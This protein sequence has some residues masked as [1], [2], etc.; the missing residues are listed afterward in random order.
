MSTKRQNMF[1]G[2]GLAVSTP[3]SLAVRAQTKTEALIVREYHKQQL[4]AGAQAV[5]AMT[6]QRLISNIIVSGVQSY[7]GTVEAIEAIRTANDRSSQAQRY[8]DDFCEHMSI[9]GGQLMAA[10]VEVGVKN[11]VEVVDLPL[12][13]ED[14]KP[15]IIDKLLGRE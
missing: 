1:S 3:T 12:Y 10:T 5:K 4:V 9:R 14:V 11:I 7:A 2:T 6:G 15:G 13:R 8:V